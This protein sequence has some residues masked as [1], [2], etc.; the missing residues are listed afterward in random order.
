MAM[1]AGPMYATCR[2]RWMTRIVC[3]SHG[4]RA[5]PSVVLASSRLATPC[6]RRASAI[7]DCEGLAESIVCLALPSTYHVTV[8]FVHTKEYSWYPMLGSNPRSTSYR[9]CVPSIQM[10]AS[11]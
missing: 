1:S 2:G 5:G 6:D 10:E 9:H 11:S 4:M 8:S 7:A 3:G